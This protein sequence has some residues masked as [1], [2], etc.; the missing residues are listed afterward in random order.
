MEVNTSGSTGRP[1]IIKLSKVS[2]MNSALAT[3]NYF[4]LLEKTTALCC[5]PL[6][7]IAGKMMIIRALCLGWHLDIVKPSSN[8]LKDLSKK[9]DFSAMVPFQVDNS[10]AFLEKINTILIGGAPVSNE[11]FVKLQTLPTQIYQSY[12]MTE[13]ITHVAVRKL[14]HLSEEKWLMQDYQALPDVDFSIDER[15]CLIINAPAL[16]VQNLIT[17]DV[18]QLVSQKEFVWRGR[19]D[20]IVNSGGIKLFPEEI[21]SQLTKIIEQP[22]F[23][24]GISDMK[25][26]EK[27]VLVVEGQESLEIDTILRSK[28][29]NLSKYQIPKEIIF[30]D[31]FLYTE[32]GKIKR[33]DTLK[34]ILP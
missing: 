5:L 24:I 34:T 28:N 8:P 19:Y 15:S 11:L 1:K 23:V 10:L 2:M 14:N 33:K 26:G 12:G 31:R 25:L 30:I 29:L 16:G 17:N 13:T 18:V 27:L 7:F 20:N 22:F 6:N 21:E 4:G 32:S 3:G 9:Y